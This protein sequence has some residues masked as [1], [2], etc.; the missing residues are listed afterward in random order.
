MSQSFY[1]DSGEVTSVN[2]RTGGIILDKSDVN[3]DRVDNTNDLEKP[4]STATQA[5]ISAEELARIS[6]DFA[7][8]GSLNAALTGLDFRHGVHIISQSV[9]LINATSGT[10]L[11][12]ILPFTDDETPILTINDFSVGKYL[13]AKN[14]ASSKLFRV[15]SELG[16]LRLAQE[17]LNTDDTFIVRY[18]LID[19]PGTQ[20]SNALFKF[21]GSDLLRIGSVNWSFANG[22]DLNPT[23]AP[24]TGTISTSD[25]VQNAIA[26]LD[27]TRAKTAGDTFTGDLTFAL[28]ASLRFT[29]GTNARTGMATLSGGAVTVTNNTITT[30]TLILLFRQS[31]AT[32]LLSNTGALFP[33]ARVV[34]TSFTVSS[35][36]GSDNGSFAWILVEKI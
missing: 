9:G 2:N 12:S 10:I 18:D 1:V 32:G 13:L 11:S 3:L 14:G 29:T 6:A 25:N 34:G 27:G 36:S 5:A 8:Q 26:K 20:E 21:D 35:T 16:V 31:Q 4:I 15:Y 30:N 28:G 7:I 24:T 33:S 17:T 23:Y 22:I 19:S